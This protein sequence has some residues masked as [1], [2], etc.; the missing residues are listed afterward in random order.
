VAT[1]KC[2]NP[3][4]PNPEFEFSEGEEQFLREKF[5]DDFKPPSYC[6]PCRAERKKQK[7]AKGE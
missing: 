1:L 6:K 5:G 7:K 4:C 2:K 3:K